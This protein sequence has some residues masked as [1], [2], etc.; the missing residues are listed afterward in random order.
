M[1]L[2]LASL[3]LVA[4][5]QARPVANPAPS[6]SAV[7]PAPLAPTFSA[8]ITSLEFQ[9]GGRVQNDVDAFV[10]VVAES[11]G[12]LNADGDRND[13]VVHVRTLNDGKVV[14]LGLAGTPVEGPG[15]VLVQV[16][17]LSQGRHDLNGDGDLRDSV[18]HVYELAS[19]KLHN[20]RVI[21]R[22]PR[23]GADWLAFLIAERDGGAD[24][25]GDRDTRD[26][27]LHVYDGP[28]A[29]LTNLRLAVPSPLSAVAPQPLFLDGSLLVA[30]AVE[31]VDT[32]D[33][34]GDGDKIDVVPQIYDHSTKSLR[35]L[36]LA[37]GT[38]DQPFTQALAAPYFA[39]GVHEGSQGLANLNGDG[40]RQDFVTHVYSAVDG[41]VRNLGLAISSLNGQFERYAFGGS[42]LAFLA[43]EA[44][45]G[46]T[47]L[48]GDGDAAD[49][50]LHVYDVLTGASEHARQRAWALLGAARHARR[51]PAR[52]AA[53]LRAE[54]GRRPER[55]RGR[56]LGARARGLRPRH[57]HAAQL[58]SRRGRPAPRR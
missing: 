14:N 25:N 48:N 42:S 38:G 24:L 20:L 43:V 3:A 50:V 11:I 37:M 18:A 15:L 21:A 30:F 31:G 12:D 36:A 8:D 55:R 41:S 6:A 33:L 2:C 23:V 58:R 19:G 49:S 28:S 1:L 53:G 45:N 17:E 34:N 29:T 22:N 56:G 52:G 27:V 32:G 51:R 57:A 54:P 4:F 16:S 13:G 9:G 46:D 35:N 39:F 5:Q 47:D 44:R 7:A 40:D 10:S 26:L